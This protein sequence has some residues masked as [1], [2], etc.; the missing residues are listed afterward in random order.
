MTAVIGATHVVCAIG[1]GTRQV[2]AS[3]RAGIGR[4]GNS[5]VM[6][7]HFESIRMGLVPEA[8]LAPLPPEVDDLPLPPRARRMLRLAAPSFRSVAKDVNLPVP[9][10]IGLPEL[11]PAEAPWLKHVPTYLQKLTGVPID[12]RRSTVVA[13]GRAAALMALDAALDS[14]R[15]DP[16]STVIVGGW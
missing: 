14:V 5:H 12:A 6:D 2:W 11:S 1:N 8:A 13:R 15:S 16:A 10:F 7:R 4:I 3:T 9:V